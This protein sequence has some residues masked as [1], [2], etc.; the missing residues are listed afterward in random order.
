[1]NNRGKVISLAQRRK[2]IL[3][4]RNTKFW[5]REG[6]ESASLVGMVSGASMNRG[7]DSS[8][9]EV[10][11][12]GPTDADRTF[13]QSVRLKMAGNPLEKPFAQHP[14][15]YACVHTIATNLA[16]TGMLVV[17]ADKENGKSVDNEFAHLLEDPNPLMSEAEFKY[18]IGVYL[19]TSGECMIV[20]E[21]A[22]GRVKSESE[23]PVEL[24]PLNGRL[25]KHDIDPDTKLVKRWILRANTPDEV[26]YE[27]HEVIHVR[28]PN[29]YDPYR[30][31]A[32]LEAATQP[33]M[34]DWAAM[35][36]NEAFFKNGGDPGGV[37]SVNRPLTDNQRQEVEDR[38]DSRFGGPSKAKR[39]L[40]LGNGAKYDSFAQSHRDMEFVTQREFS[41]NEILMVFRVPPAEAGIYED[42]NNATAKEESKRFWTR[43]MFPIFGFVEDSLW[44]GL[45]RWASRGKF[46]AVF[47][48]KSIPEIL[49]SLD[50]LIAAAQKLIGMGYT[51]EQA[52]AKV[53]LDMPVNPWQKRSWVSPNLV[54]QGSLEAAERA[55]EEADTTTASDAQRPT[56]PQITSAINV[57]TLVNAGQLTR[58]QGIALL[59]QFFPGMTKEAAEALIGG[60]KPPA[61]A[62]SL[63]PTP[64]VPSPTPPVPQEAP[65]ATPAAPPSTATPAA[66]T[67]PAA[68]ISDA[69][70]DRRRNYWKSLHEEHYGPEEGKYRGMIKRYLVA[71]RAE[72]LRKTSDG[73]KAFHS[74]AAQLFTLEEIA[75]I[76]QWAKGLKAT[77]PLSAKH[78][79]LHERAPKAIER[80]LFDT[81]TWKNKL[82]E[83]SR[84]HYAR[85]VK[86]AQARLAKQ[87]HYS[88][89]FSEK[90]ARG[91]VD[92][93]A[94]KVTGI[95]E[96]VRRNLREQIGDA[97][98]EGG[99]VKEVQNA[100]RSVF[101][102]SLARS[103][104]IARTEVGG[105]TSRA[106]FIGM[107]EA[108][109]QKLEWVSAG[110]ELVRESHRIDGEVVAVGE[111]FSNGI[112]FPHD[113]EG[114]AE[115][116][117]NCRCDIAPVIDEDGTD[118]N[119]DE[120][121]SED[122][123]DVLIEEK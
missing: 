61:P 87:I 37:I 72:Q 17:E 36:Y 11:S 13:F 95:T 104:T 71:L 89:G 1:M 77:D 105:A 103:L 62:S 107:G 96:T 47:D 25:F 53:G 46:C 39:L 44:A 80:V 20:K 16:G 45:F 29:P 86:S 56:G 117:I 102:V 15:I 48:R 97:V 110:D 41:R 88:G 108:G 69:G 33:L 76:K 3:D 55:A 73:I 54:S 34:T 101:K 14:I 35:Q 118:D 70:F 27:P 57:I 7:P 90:E 82:A 113:P 59:Q 116:T 67:A 100:V 19:E 64:T 6:G 38:Y 81:L 8:G 52:A 85:V 30:G 109:V 106:T 92:T 122:G 28:Y 79:A 40:V 23:V 78:L 24:W 115:D 121:E 49:E 4:T 83:A 91:L 94:S 2:R 66:I 18:M 111:E 21:G 58:D 98:V 50:D 68:P 43:T 12:I 123:D 10:K 26:S 32:P 75:E 65:P 93:F 119:F 74:G 120:V 51:A 84:P 112:R 9:I 63:S 60:T 114:D 42:V 99:G 22:D 5:E 31:L